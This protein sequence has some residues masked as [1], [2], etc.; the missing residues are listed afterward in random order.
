MK[1]DPPQRLAVRLSNLLQ[2]S[3]L[4]LHGSTGGLSTWWDAKNASWLLVS[5]PQDQSLLVYQEAK[6]VNKHEVG[7]VI[8]GRI[9]ITQNPV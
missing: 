7:E 4:Y 3:I 5:T 9:R 8:S 6:G 2:P 1:V